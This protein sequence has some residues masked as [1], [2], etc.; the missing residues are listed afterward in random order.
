GR[1][2]RVLIAEDDVVT[3]KLLNRLLTKFG[4]D[5]QCV[6]NG[7]E[8]WNAIQNEH[9]PV[10]VSDWM[11]PGIEGVELCRRLRELKDRPYSYVILLTSRDERDDRFQA[12]RSGVDDVLA[13]PIDLEELECRMAV[14]TRIIKME[15][16]L[17]E[18][19]LQLEESRA[20]LEHSNAVLLTKQQ[21]VE[22]LLAQAERTSEYAQEANR[23]FEQL[24]GEIPVAGFSCDESTKI[25]E[26]NKKAEEIFGVPAD[27]AVEK[28]MRSVIGKKLLTR[29]ALDAIHAVFQGVPFVDQEWKAGDRVLLVSGYPMVGYNNKISGCLATAVDISQLRKIEAELRTKMKE[30]RAANSKIEEA[31]RK[32]SEMAVTDGLTKIANRRALMD[33][34]A[35]CL[36]QAE[37]GQRFTLAMIDV[38]HFKK[39]N[40]EFGHQA[41]DEI[42]IAVAQTLKSSVRKLD[43]VAR[44]GG[45]EFCVL[46]V[47][48]SLRSAVKMA[49][50]IRKR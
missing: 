32:L 14:G 29:K 19:N 45:E 12:L 21:E 4:Y 39:F 49:E 2:M 40:D 7:L 3:N 33:R 13:K 42:L 47:N 43:F 8:A 30:L 15:H 37:R 31:N 6:F 9:F 35:I 18:Q 48:A 25:F 23:R 24:F 10:V 5:C 11:M 27:R 44:Y 17:K 28:P 38:D 22:R 26:W 46:F 41:G 1:D 36:E 20:Q 50:R 16:H 34:L